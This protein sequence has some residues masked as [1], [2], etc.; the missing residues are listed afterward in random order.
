M[1]TQTGTTIEIVETGERMIVKD[2]AIRE[3][4]FKIENAERSG[5]SALIAKDYDRGKRDGINTMKDR[6][7]NAMRGI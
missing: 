1:I 6:I 3:F 2:P 5:A 4:M 7:H